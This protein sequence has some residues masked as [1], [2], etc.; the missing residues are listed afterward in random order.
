MVRR[1][2][3]YRMGLILLMQGELEEAMHVLDSVVQSAEKQLGADDQLT[4]EM[5]RMAGVARKEWIEETEEEKQGKVSI[6][7]GSVLF[8]RDVSRL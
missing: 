8:W 1:G 7:R 3:G 2:E 5:R 4:I 6:R